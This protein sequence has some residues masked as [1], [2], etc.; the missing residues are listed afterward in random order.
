MIPA[1]RRRAARRLRKAMIVIGFA[2]GFL[3]ATIIWRAVS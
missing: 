2:L 3:T 1:A